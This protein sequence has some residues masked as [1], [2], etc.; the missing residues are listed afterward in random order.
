MKNNWK[1]VSDFNVELEIRLRRWSKKPKPTDW[2]GGNPARW[3][4]IKPIT[5]EEFLKIIGAV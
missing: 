4:D 1:Q 5:N 2:S 3:D